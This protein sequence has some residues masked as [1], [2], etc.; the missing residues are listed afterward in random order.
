MMSGWLPRAKC[1]SSLLLLLAPKES[2]P[3]VSS[4]G[5]VPVDSRQVDMG[6]DHQHLGADSC[7]M[8]PRVYSAAG[9]APCAEHRERRN[10]V[11]SS[12]LVG[13]LY[14]IDCYVCSSLC[15]AAGANQFRSPAAIPVVAAPWF[16]RWRH[17]RP[18]TSVLRICIGVEASTDARCCCKSARTQNAFSRKEDQENLHCTVKL[19]FTS[20]AAESCNGGD[21][22]DT[23]TVRLARS[24][25]PAIARA[26]RNGT[27]RG[28]PRSLQHQRP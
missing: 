18:N 1:P 5:C 24:V 6:S 17:D 9:S 2:R 8:D 14:G 26:T 10:R 20:A 22:V 15:I 13:W 12:H 25:Q 16:L 4:Q 23:D 3:P 27:A 21:V 11:V 7:K 28:E 19:S